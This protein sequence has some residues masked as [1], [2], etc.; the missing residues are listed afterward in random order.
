MKRNSLIIKKTVSI[1]V[2]LSLFVVQIGCALF[3]K[4]ARLESMINAEKYN[5]A[6][7]FYRENRDDIDKGD[8]VNVFESALDK[9]YKNYLNGKTDRRDIQEYINDLEKVQSDALDSYG[10]GILNDV[11][12][13]EL[14]REAFLKAENAFKNS[15]YIEAIS[16]YEQV[17]KDDTNYNDAQKQ[18]SECRESYK[19]QKISEAEKYA[20]KEDYL[21][22]IKLLKD[23]VAIAGESDEI[24]SL[25]NTYQTK[26][27]DYIFN[28]AASLEKEAK[29][30]EAIKLLSDNKS[31][32]SD[33]K[34]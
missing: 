6:L 31:F 18:I 3:N 23:A 5:E 9:M 19:K 24:N 7:D 10:E 4:T 33:S 22:A 29:Y 8:A 28:T 17:I 27:D 14:S 26:F 12:K 32:V 34:K 30:D 25:M 1:M 13:V 16:Y 20:Q 2:L 21:N 15:S 11:N